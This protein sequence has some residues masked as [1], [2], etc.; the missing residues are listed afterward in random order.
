M[1]SRLR[2]TLIESSF[3]EALIECAGVGY[4]VNIPLCTYDKLPQPGNEAVLHTV[5]IVREDDMSLYGFATQRELKIFRLLCTVNGIGAKTALNILS[6]L[7]IPS[8]CQAILSADIRSLKK[9]NGVGPKSAERM[10]VELRDKIR[11]IDPSAEY[12]AGA[13][14]ASGAAP[15]A[16]DRNT[17]DAIMAL[18][19]LGFQRAKIQKCVIDIAASLPEKERSVENIIRHSL[20]SLNKG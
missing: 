1:I 2:G 6:S 19:K 11:D 12:A 8:F 17:E 4:S 5:L 20:Q 9:I 16:I 3:T 15:A 7:N 13:S 14:G 10:V 18:E